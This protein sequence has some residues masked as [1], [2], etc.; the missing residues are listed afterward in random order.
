MRPQM[1]RFAV[2]MLLVCFVLVSSPGAWAW[3]VTVPASSLAGENN[4][5]AERLLDWV[6]SLIDRHQT[7]HQASAPEPP[8]NQP[9]EGSQMDPNGQH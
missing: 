4:S 3:P 7:S 5:W 9:K 6:Q 8:R 1:T 2:A